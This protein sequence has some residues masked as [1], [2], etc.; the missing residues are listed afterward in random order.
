MMFYFGLSR[1]HRL[2]YGR[3]RLGGPSYVLLFA[4]EENDEMVA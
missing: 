3:S 2:L 4:K 1:N